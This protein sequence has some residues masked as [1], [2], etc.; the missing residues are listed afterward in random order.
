MQK[1]VIRINNVIHMLWR[2]KKER[3]RYRKKIPYKVLKPCLQ[4]AIH[5]ELLVHSRELR[6]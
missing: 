5:I 6:K 4:I 1:F 3:K 2:G